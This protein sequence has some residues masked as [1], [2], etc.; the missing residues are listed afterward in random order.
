MSIDLT[1]KNFVYD[2]GGRKKKKKRPYTQRGK[3]ENIDLENK[4]SSLALKQTY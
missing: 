4:K 2:S 3:Q 1:E